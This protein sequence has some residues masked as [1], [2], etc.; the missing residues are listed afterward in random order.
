MS[1][2][3]APTSSEEGSR[4]GPS[5]GWTRLPDHEAGAP[6]PADA[7]AGS[8]ADWSHPPYRPYPQ[9][10]G[11]FPTT[12]PAPGGGQ[13]PWTPD[14]RTPG[15]NGFAIAALVCGLLPL[16]PLALIF[17]VIALGQV[18]E[19]RQ[20]GRWHAIVG[21]VAA[22]VWTAVLVLG[23]TPTQVLRD[24]GERVSWADRADGECV[25]GLSGLDADD[26]PRPADLPVVPCTGPHEGEIY[27]V[28]QL[29]DGTGD[30]AR[31]YPGQPAARQ[32][33]D[34]RCR[35]EMRTNPPSTVS[36]DAIVG[37]IYVYPLEYGWP[38]QRTAVCIAYDPQDVTVPGV[39]PIPGV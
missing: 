7:A 24:D 8:R 32:E 37:Y 18:A 13:P 26:L 16:I 11:P 36:T 28:F 23:G 1:E 3:A 25:D 21:M 38:E 33:T 2:P 20:D 6:G 12:G 15:T 22:G 39:A 5:A 9:H 30:E 29:G 34:R 31:A 14:Q 10:Q 27:A 35:D 17:G 4:R 19:R